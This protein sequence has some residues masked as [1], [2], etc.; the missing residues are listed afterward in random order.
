M[1]KTIH[2]DTTQIPPMQAQ[3]LGATFL[4]AVKEFYRNP[5]NV[6]KYE[7]WARQK[8]IKS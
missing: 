8:Q 2:I 1:L 7:E 5:E 3:L 6:K 4:A